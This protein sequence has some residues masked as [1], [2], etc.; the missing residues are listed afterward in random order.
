MPE[1]PVEREAICSAV[2]T[3]VLKEH[4][5]FGASARQARVMLELLTSALPSSS[6]GSTLCSFA[7]VLDCALTN[8]A[9]SN[10]KTLLTYWK[11]AVRAVR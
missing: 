6:P 2:I 10:S 8:L 3:A 4:N 7:L 5:R 1:S 9:S 11:S